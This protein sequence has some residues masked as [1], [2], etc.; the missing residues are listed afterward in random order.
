MRVFPGVSFQ[1]EFA[2]EL[3]RLLPFAGDGVNSDEAS[4]VLRVVVALQSAAVANR[5][6]RRRRRDRRSS[7]HLPEMLRLLVLAEFVSKIAHMPS[8]PRAGCENKRGTDSE[9][10]PAARGSVV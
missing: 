5:N 10:C 2:I 6:E 9:M 1:A 3:S 8:T 4:A 7:P